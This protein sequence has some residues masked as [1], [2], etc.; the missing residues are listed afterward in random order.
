MKQNGAELGHFEIPAHQEAIDKHFTLK[1]VEYVSVP[2]EQ[3]YP[4]MCEYIRKLCKRR[5]YRFLFPV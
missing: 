1:S 4:S 3:T 2:T 5:I